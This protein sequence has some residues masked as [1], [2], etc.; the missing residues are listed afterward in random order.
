[1][2]IEIPYPFSVIY[3]NHPSIKYTCVLFTWFESIRFF[4]SYNSIR[5]RSIKKS[6]FLF[7]WKFFH[8]GFFFQ[9][10][11][12]YLKNYFGRFI[13]PCN[14]VRNTN[15]IKTIWV[16]FVRTLVDF[17]YTKE[18]NNAAVSCQSEA[19]TFIITVIGRTH[20]FLRLLRIW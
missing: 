17:P 2:W 19:I 12:C 4:C 9:F 13:Q 16:N 18:W 14:Q 15:K 5:K 10:R 7:Y 8:Y 11:G 6:K 20:G 1:M 3:M